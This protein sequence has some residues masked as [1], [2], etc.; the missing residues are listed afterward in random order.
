[1]KTPPH[2]Q[3]ELNELID[4]LR[5]N[6]DSFDEVHAD[7]EALLTKTDYFIKVEVAMFKRRKYY[8]VERSEYNFEGIRAH[9]ERPRY[10]VEPTTSSTFQTFEL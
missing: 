9:A 6:E 1:M 10:L 3:Q 4:E 8:V 7:R 5:F 2:I